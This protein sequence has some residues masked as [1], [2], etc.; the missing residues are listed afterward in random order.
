MD[1]W[2]SPPNMQIIL[3]VS[4]V[5]LD[6]VIAPTLAKKG[7]DHSSAARYWQVRPEI[8]LMPI[9]FGSCYA[10]RIVFESCFGYTLCWA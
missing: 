3:L 2:D 5:A 7:L 6:F 10:Y 8:G 1:D 4:V 9:D